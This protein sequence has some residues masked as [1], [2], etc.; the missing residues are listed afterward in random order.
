MDF[1]ERKPP[2]RT[3]TLLWDRLT[4]FSIKVNIQKDDGD[5]FSVVVPRDGT[6]KD[7][8][9]VILNTKYLSAKNYTLFVDGVSLVN[10]EEKLS[11]YK[12]VN[13]SVVV[14]LSIF[15]LA[16]LH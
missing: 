1:L 11:Q 3:V 16:Y 7:L 4:G 2:K 10:P 13:S 12:V 15:F 8:Q 6:V 5:E 14:C 9:G